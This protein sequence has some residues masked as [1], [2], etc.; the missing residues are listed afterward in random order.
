VLDTVVW[1]LD[2]STRKKQIQ[3]NHPWNLT[4]TQNISPIFLHNQYTNNQEV[5]S[6]Q[7]QYSSNHQNPTN[8]PKNIPEKSALLQKRIDNQLNNDGIPPTGK[9]RFILAILQKGIKHKNINPQ[10]KSD[11]NLLTNFNINPEALKPQ[12]W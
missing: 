4:W 2:D 3:S 1:I 6:I 12:Q 11:P 7:T 9:G 8:P 5:F 10:T